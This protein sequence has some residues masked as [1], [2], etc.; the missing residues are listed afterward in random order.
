MPTP[1]RTLVLVLACLLTLGACASS[2]AAPSDSASTVP[3]PSA[4]VGASAA[5]APTTLPGCASL[6]APADEGRTHIPDGAT[7]TYG[8]YP[9]TSGPHAITPANPGWYQ[10]MP[11][12]EQLVHSLEH[13][14]IVVYRSGLDAAG[15]A[16]LK[17]RFDALVTQGYRGLISV[18][19]PSLKDP[20]TLTAWD[21]L[22][23]CVRAEPDALEGFVQAHYAQSPEAYVACALPGAA[24]LPVCQE[25]LA[26]ASP[27]PSRAPTAADQALLARVPESLRA[28]CRPTMTLAQGADAGWDCFPAPG[29]FVYGYASF[30]TPAARDA[31][32]EGIVAALGTL[33]AA[34]CSAASTG[35]GTFKRA[36][37]ST[38]R[39]AC[40][41]SNG[42]KAY[43]WTVDGSGDLGAALTLG[44]S[45][46]HAFFEAAG[47]A[48][49]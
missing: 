47:P 25:V 1:H 2:P 4:S 21:R 8:S 40:S 24:S 44:D 16:A 12:I 41:V 9:P 38:G 36:D 48:A 39:L 27:A 37:G 35:L 13:G 10:T 20:M 29:D 32:F 31:Y 3:G 28:D 34:D 22:Q 6:E 17:A 42:A 14:F 7:A 11:P 18:P 15:E 30:P 45:D 43:Y 46:L 26:N 19:D 23:R 49:P 5:A 33:P